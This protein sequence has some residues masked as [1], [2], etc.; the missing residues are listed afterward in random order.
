MQFGLTFWVY[1]STAVDGALS[2]APRAS[3][4]Q[5]TDSQQIHTTVP[6][7]CIVDTPA[8]VAAAIAPAVGARAPPP[9]PAAAA[10]SDGSETA[11]EYS[12]APSQPPPPPL[13][14]QSSP[15]GMPRSEV[16]P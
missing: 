3:T 12:E 7:A 5:L 13:S 14:R 11:P 9:A 6:V 2:E 1:E 4:P 16:R 8:A 15:A 10:A